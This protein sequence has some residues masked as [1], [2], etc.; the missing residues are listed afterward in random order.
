MFITERVLSINKHT[1]IRL[2][3]CQLK[4]AVIMNIRLYMTWKVP[5]QLLPVRAS[6]IKQNNVKGITP[7]LLDFDGAHSL[8]TSQ[9]HG[10]N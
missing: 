8:I 3:V 6:P 2:D 5:L 1:R 4:S 9:M 7:P 10:F